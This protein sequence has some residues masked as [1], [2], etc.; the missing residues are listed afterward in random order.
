MFF[1]TVHTIGA[2]TRK[3]QT[4]SVKML[5]SDYPPAPPVL[6]MPPNRIDPAKRPAIAE[7]LNEPGNNRCADCDA[8]IDMDNT[9]AVLSYGILVCDDCKL[10]HIEHQNHY[11]PPEEADSNDSGAN[12]KVQWL[13]VM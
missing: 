5:R 1:C 10:V 2:S 12:G 9:W 3:T 7:L 4:I 8:A 11:K 6:S 13:L